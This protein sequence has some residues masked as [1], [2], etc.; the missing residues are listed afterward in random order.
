VK[1]SRD[2]AAAARAAGDDVTLVE[3]DADHREVIDPQHPAWTPVPAWL[4]E[5]LS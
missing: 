2:F 5:R 3:P 1:R 4:R